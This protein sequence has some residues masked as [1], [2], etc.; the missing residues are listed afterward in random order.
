MSAP[1]S[2]PSGGQ[3]VRQIKAAVPAP[4]KAVLRPAVR[5]VLPVEVETPAAPPAD[6]AFCDA[7][8]P[9]AWTIHN[10]RTQRE[11]R[12][13]FLCGCWK[14]GTHWIQNILNLHPQVNMK[15][16]YHFEV[17]LRAM[18]RFT[19]PHWFVGHGPKARRIAA[20]AMQ[21][22]VRR[23]MFATTRD[24]PEALWLGD[25]TPRHLREVLP[26]AP[27][28]WLLRDGRDVLVSWSFH[29]LRVNN[30]G[31]FNHRFKAEIERFTP[32]F[33]ANPD[34]FRNPDS[35]LLG[36]DRWVRRTAREWAAFVRND[37]TQFAAMTA[38]GTPVHKVVYEDLHTR[39]HEGAAELY[40]FLGL[41]PAEAQPL[42]SESKTLPGFKK[43]NLKSATRKGQTGD[44]R[45]YFNE[46]ITRIFKEEAGQAL[47]DAG[48]E[49][50][51]DW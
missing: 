51:L 4:L 30:T 29:W 33:A 50:D 8:A 47:I 9:N 39:P 42:S 12:F 24:R 15:G 1:K 2:S 28:I 22:L 31:V 23:T 19:A 48:Y 36:N 44:W 32:E 17:M 7:P 40:R 46:R 26:G 6:L 3:L 34:K 41:D 21:N 5:A 38:A 37:I 14:S 11:H 10:P 16:E 45:N 35:G 27:S 25:R 43:E 13:F 49:K 18:H 20:S